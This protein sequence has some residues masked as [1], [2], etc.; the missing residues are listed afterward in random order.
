MREDKYCKFKESLKNDFYSCLY[1]KGLNKKDIDIAF[2]LC[3]EVFIEYSSNKYESVFCID[4]FNSEYSFKLFR[5]P[6]FEI[7]IDE[8]IPDLSQVYRHNFDKNIIILKLCFFLGNACAVDSTLSRAPGP[9]AAGA[10]APTPQ[11]NRH[12]KGRP[13]G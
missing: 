2:K 12:G 10:R 6:L 4:N 3:K 11:V 9:A 7:D 5:I 1:N 8:C 13:P